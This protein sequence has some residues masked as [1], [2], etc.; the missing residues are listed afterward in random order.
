MEQLENKPL[1]PQQ[2]RQLPMPKAAWLL[3]GTLCIG[4]GFA[5]ILLDNWSESLQTC[6]GIYGLCWGIYLAGYYIFVGKRAIRKWECWY[7][8]CGAG[9]LVLHSGLYQAAQL[10]MANI[11]LIP[12]VL[13]LHA[14]W[15]A[16]EVPKERAWP[17]VQG[18]LLG[19]FVYPFS[20][21]DTWF[22]AIGKLF[23]GKTGDDQ[24]RLAR[25]NVWLGILFGLPVLILVSALLLKADLAMGKVLGSWLKNLPDLSL[26]R[27]LLMLVLAVLFYSFLYNLAFGQSPRV[28]Q[29]AEPQPKLPGLSFITGAGM[30]LAVYGIFAI[31]QFTY[32][33][34]LKGLPEGLTYSEYAVSGF[35][36]LLWVAAINLGV[37]SLGLCQA[38][39]HP[40]RKPILWG[41]LAATALLLLSAALR[42]GMY[43]QAYALT[44]KRGLSL[45]L[46]LYLAAVVVLCGWALLGRKGV[47]RLCALVL[48]GWYVA[49]NLVN[50]EGMIANS[51]FHRADQRGG[52]LAEGDAD[53]LRYTLSEDAK[54]AIVKSGYAEQVYYDVQKEDLPR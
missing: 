50:V 22:L 49:L 46:M 29:D 10:S 21:I 33:T 3:L 48:V 13:M 53:Y 4:Y 2:P 16:L 15:G 38:K 31:F 44:W 35:S 18:Y 43:I 28:S 11:L 39:P 25:R 36:E 34:G 14:T 26:G 7:L 45:W 52:V 41:L 24:R 8:A 19:W 6:M 20:K 23:Q 30:L 5:F 12:M 1:T 27:I 17:W 47:L 37:F 54:Q 51:I 32:L 40:A 9:L 42:L